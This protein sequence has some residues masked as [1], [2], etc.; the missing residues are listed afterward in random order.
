M[1]MSAFK[2]S[3]R[4]VSLTAICLLAV[5]IT[6]SPLSSSSPQAAEPILIGGVGP[7]S[8]PG[9]VEA[10]L[11]M[12]WAMDAAVAD[13][14]AKG[15]VLHRQLALDFE[16]TRATPAVGA[17]VAKRFVDE[18][19]AVAVVGEFHSNAALAAIPTYE[20]ADMPFIVV[21]AASDAITAGDP[22]SADLPTNPRSIFRTLPPSSMISGIMGQWIVEGLHAKKVLHVYE[23][24][25]YGLSS[26]AVFKKQMDDAHVEITQVPVELGQSDYSSIM[27]RLAQTNG[28]VNAVILDTTGD[29]NYILTENAFQAGL[30]K[31]GR[32]CV[33][34]QIASDSTAFWRAAPDGAGCSFRFSGPLPGHYNALEQ[35]VAE[36]YQAKFNRPPKPWV[37]ESYDAVLLVADAI[38]RAGS[39][40]HEKVVRAL[41]TTNLKG[42][43]GTY[44]FPYNSQ[45]PVPAGQPGWK[46]HNWLQPQLSMVEYTRK[47]QTLS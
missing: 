23:D 25:D 41:E 27:Q 16:D 4:W 21:E 5:S 15:G 28:D 14:N 24:S 13:V 11:D 33:V 9:A 45:H 1:P 26:K 22:K 32:V 29:S 2:S 12:K 31:P 10:G 47:G 7:L 40:D 35:S 3:N 44:S 37:F 43:L 6:L 46:W 30:L 20:K 42:C 18:T 36:R 17:Q 38:A 19:Q 34:N 8:Q 39:T